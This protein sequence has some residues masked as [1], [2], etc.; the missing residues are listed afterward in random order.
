MYDMIQM[1]SPDQY[2]EYYNW[3][4]EYNSDQTQPPEIPTV[5]DLQCQFPEVGN[6][7]AVQIAVSW[8]ERKERMLKGG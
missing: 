6:F 3:L 1:G 7:E 4:D 2:D 5:A 8:M